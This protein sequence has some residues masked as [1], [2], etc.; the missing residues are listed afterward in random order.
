MD[1]DVEVDGFFKEDIDMDIEVDVEV[2][3]DIVRVMEYWKS[4]EVQGIYY[5]PIVW[6]RTSF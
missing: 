5:G 3:V 2:D 1:A 4:S 6:V